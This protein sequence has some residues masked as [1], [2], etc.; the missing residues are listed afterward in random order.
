[1]AAQTL[2]NVLHHVVGDLRRVTGRAASLGNGNTWDTGLETILA[3]GVITDTASAGQLVGGT[4]SGGTITL[5]LEGGT[6]AAYLWAE[7]Y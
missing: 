7:G 4:V 5:A 3:W 1:M 2:T 6:P